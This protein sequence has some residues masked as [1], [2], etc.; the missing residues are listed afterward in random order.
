MLFLSSPF[1]G[2]GVSANFTY[3]DRAAR[4]VPGRTETVPNFLQSKYTGT[5][6]LFYENSGFTARLAYTYRSK[7]LDTLGAT[8]ASDQYTAENNALDARVSYAPVKQFTIFAEGSNL[9]DS[10]WRR[11]QATEPQLIENERYCQVYRI[12]VLIAL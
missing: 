8:A 11:F 4:G 7:C 3:T 9:L 6:Q 5:A 10:P 2:P 12:G 1:D